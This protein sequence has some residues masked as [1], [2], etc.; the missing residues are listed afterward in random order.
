MITLIIKEIHKHFMNW[1]LGD[2]RPVR[3][4]ILLLSRL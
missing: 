4:E 2:T 1:I 3:F